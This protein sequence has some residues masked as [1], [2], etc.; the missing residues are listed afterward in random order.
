MKIS[1]KRLNYTVADATSQGGDGSGHDAALPF[2][3]TF[4]LVRDWSAVNRRGLTQTDSEGTPHVFGV[5]IAAYGSVIAA[6]GGGATTADEGLSDDDVRNSTVTVR[7]YGVANS[8]LMK[9]ASRKAHKAREKMFRDAGVKKSDRGAY[10]KT[11]RYCLA[12]NSESLMTPVHSSTRSSYTM[13]TWDNTQIIFPDDV[14]GAYLALSGQHASEESTD[15][16]TQ[17]SI[18]QMY[19]ASRGTIDSDSNRESSTTPADNSVLAKMLANY[20]G[21]NDEVK[22]L[23]RGEQD[24]P[25]YDTTVVNGDGVHLVELGRLQFNP[26]TS[27]GSA[28]YIEV[29]FGMVYASF[30]IL[31]HGDSDADMSLD[32]SMECTAIASM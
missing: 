13:G 25:P 27:G 22:V 2:Y 12:S 4:N 9:Q 31:D 14:G 23:A 17:L 20:R 5:N 26:F 10:S 6:S 18:A 28:T 29:P 11:I 16:F 21:S 19:L 30:Q 8:W 1:Q 15:A 7:F 3:K 32:L 24:N